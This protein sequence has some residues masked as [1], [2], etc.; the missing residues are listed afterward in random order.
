MSASHLLSIKL[1]KVF[2]KLILYAG[3]SVY[4]TELGGKGF[5]LPCPFSE[6]MAELDWGQAVTPVD[7]AGVGILDIQSQSIRLT[8]ELFKRTDSGV[9]SKFN[10]SRPLLPRVPQL[11]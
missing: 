6:A 11:F 8:R 10:P 4:T 2:L 9:P 3:D 5:N 7:Q 1:T